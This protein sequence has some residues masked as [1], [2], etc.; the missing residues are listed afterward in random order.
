VWTLPHLYVRLCEFAYEVYDATRHP[1]LGQSPREAFEK[2][3]AAT[4]HRLQRVVPY[5]REF[6]VLTLPAPRKGTVRVQAGRGAKVN[7]LYYWSEAFRNP[8]V[9]G[10]LVAVRYEPFDAGTAYAFVCGQWVEC[11][12]ELYTTFRG[13][14][15]KEIMLASRELMKRHQNHAQQLNINGRRLAEFIQSVEAE[16]ALLTQRLRD[17]ESQEVRSGRS[18]AIADNDFQGGVSEAGGAALGSEPESEP[19]GSYEIYGEF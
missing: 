2:G 9:E 19:P 15:E 1:S 4:G 12:S 3:L 8:E 16:E 18:I 11:H 14:S 10:Q 5:D 17:R 7:Y 6:V 13:R